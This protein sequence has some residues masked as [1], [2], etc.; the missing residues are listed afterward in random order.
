MIQDSESKNCMN[1]IG[2]ENLKKDMRQ[3]NDNRSAL[4]VAGI[5]LGISTEEIVEIVREVREKL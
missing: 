1:E 4:D 3:K 5:G 2:T